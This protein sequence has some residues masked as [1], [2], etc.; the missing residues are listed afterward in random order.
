MRQSANRKRSFRGQRPQAR[1]ANTRIHNQKNLKKSTK[2]D[3]FD[4]IYCVSR[5][6]VGAAKNQNHLLVVFIFVKEAPTGC[7]RATPVAHGEYADKQLANPQ[8]RICLIEFLRLGLVIDCQGAMLGLPRQIK[9]HFCGF[10]FVSQHFHEFVSWVSKITTVS[11][12]YELFIKKGQ[13]SNL[14]LCFIV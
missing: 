4:F 6:D 14:F 7:A 3:F 10:F 13:K 5:G 9:P 12:I 2:G 8:K 1:M 11:H